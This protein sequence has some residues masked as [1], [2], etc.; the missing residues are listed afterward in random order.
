MSNDLM[1]AMPWQCMFVP[2][3]YT[4]ISIILHLIVFL[5]VN[6]GVEELLFQGIS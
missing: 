4:T 1:H 5:G 6:L 3:E 2:Y